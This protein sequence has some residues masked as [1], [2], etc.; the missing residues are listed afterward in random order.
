MM[1]MNRLKD[2]GHEIE[3]KVEQIKTMISKPEPNPLSWPQSEIQDSN[4]QGDSDSES[5][6]VRTNAV[7]N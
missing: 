1:I 7:L 5:D 4:D 3:S 6:E 2:Q